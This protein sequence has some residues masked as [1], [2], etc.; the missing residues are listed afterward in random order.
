EAMKMETDVV[1]SE[2]GT[3]VDIPVTVG[4]QVIVGQ[5]L[6]ATQA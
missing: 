4:D 6:I 1:A 2:S 5:P 3:V